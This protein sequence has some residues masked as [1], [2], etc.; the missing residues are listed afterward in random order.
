MPTIVVGA[1]LPTPCG[2]ISVK[3]AINIPFSIDFSF[4]LNFKFKIYIPW[5]D[6]S[7]IKRIGS[8][9]EPKEDSQP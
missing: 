1:K 2:D 7:I 4:F 8:A 9:P 6:C 5:P 3:K